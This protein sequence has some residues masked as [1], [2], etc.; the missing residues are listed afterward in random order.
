MQVN[1]AGISVLLG[2]EFHRGFSFRCS[3]LPVY[4][5]G[6]ELEGKAQ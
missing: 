1:S 3:G 2:I 6:G 4:R 5:F